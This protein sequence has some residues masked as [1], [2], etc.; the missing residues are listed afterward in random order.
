MGTPV[1]TV[2]HVWTVE[3]LLALGEEARYELIEGRLVPMSPTGLLH[4]DVEL[5]LAA[6]LRAFVHP[7]R[8]GRVVVGEV[9]L[10][11][12]G[13]RTRCGRRMWPSSAPNASPRRPPHRLLR[14]SPRPG[15]GDP[16]PLRPLR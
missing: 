2:E 12:G 7:R 9:G 4:G 14:G 8:L 1:K 11:C 13:I 6:A 10:C 5:A 15:R 16:L 3:E